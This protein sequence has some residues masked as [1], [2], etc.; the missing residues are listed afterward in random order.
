MKQSQSFESTNGVSCT[1]V[2][3]YIVI[4]DGD[5]QHNYAHVEQ[6][7]ALSLPARES[8]A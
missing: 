6:K 4:P 8:V 2:V 3:F 5:G 1:V 7:T